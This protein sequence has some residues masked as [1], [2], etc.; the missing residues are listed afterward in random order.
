MLRKS[1]LVDLIVVITLINR[2]FGPI[3]SLKVVP[4][5]DRYLIRE[6]L[7]VSRGVSAMKAGLG[8]SDIAVVVLTKLTGQLLDVG[9]TT[10]ARR[11]RHMGG[12]ALLTQPLEIVLVV[13]YFIWLELVV[14]MSPNI[15]NYP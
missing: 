11:L 13:C 3:I 12:L 2:C 6:L 1:R 10:V 7:L 14:M 9:V 8:V 15:L 5:P 4:I